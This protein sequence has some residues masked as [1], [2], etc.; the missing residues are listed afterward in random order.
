MA[1]RIERLTKETL[2]AGVWL[3]GMRAFNKAGDAFFENVLKVP[4]DMDYYSETI[5]NLPQIC[6][7]FYKIFLISEAVVTFMFS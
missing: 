5:K 4:V 3:F 7:L 2:S 6:L 1:W